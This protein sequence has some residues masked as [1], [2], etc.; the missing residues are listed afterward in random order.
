ML[1]CGRPSDIYA[2]GGAVIVSFF[3][4][5]QNNQNMQVR[6]KMLACNPSASCFCCCA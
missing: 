5:V 6:M 4:W 2:N 3:E 1:L